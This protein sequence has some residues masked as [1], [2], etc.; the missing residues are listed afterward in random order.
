MFTATV[1]SANTLKE[2]VQFVSRAM[3][4]KSS[5]GPDGQKRIL[6]HTERGQLRLTGSDREYR[7]ATRAVALHGQA[8]EL[9]VAV[10][11]EDLLAALKGW[12]PT[13]KSLAIEHNGVLKLGDTV[14]PCEGGELPELLRAAEEVAFT[15][16]QED[17]RAAFEALAPALCR[18]ET[19]PVL[20]GARLTTGL[21]G[22]ELAASDMYRLTTYRLKTARGEGV[23]LSRQVIVPGNLIRL[24]L[25]HKP[26]PR[27]NCVPATF[28]LS[29]E[30]ITLSTDT[31]ILTGRLVEGE[32]PN[33]ERCI[34]DDLGQKRTLPSS[35][36]REAV[37]AVLPIAHRDSKRVEVHFDGE[38]LAVTAR[39]LAGTVCTNSQ[40]CGEGNAWRQWFNGQFLAEALRLFDVTAGGQGSEVL[41]ES[42]DPLRPIKLTGEFFP[43][44]HVLM[45][46]DEFGC[47]AGGR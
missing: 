45:P 36:F 44:V 10:K 37:E 23:G 15:V 41:V 39:D 7:Q 6:L 34:P 12:Q 8:G 33:V 21:E 5:V 18:D 17:L 35:L 2:E 42:D 27:G 20:T 31:V 13:Y 26:D 14:V 19:R 29:D 25:E 46:M 28:A 47:G 32:F 38:T 16:P 24:Y 1:T 11:P 22:V 9:R 3:P 4:S 40:T 43:G 30:T